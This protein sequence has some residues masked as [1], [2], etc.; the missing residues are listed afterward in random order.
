MVSVSGSM[1]TGNGAPNNGPCGTWWHGS[2]DYG[3][4][5]GIVGLLIGGNHIPIEC[6]Q[7]AF[8]VPYP[9]RVYAYVNDLQ[10]ENNSGS[11]S[12]SITVYPASVGDQDGDGLEDALEDALLDW[13][14]PQL[15]FDTE[16]DIRPCDAYYFLRVSSLRDDTN[17]GYPIVFEQAPF[18]PE[19]GLF[20]IPVLIA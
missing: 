15:K 4:T 13:Y 17:G 3:Y 18:Y 6:G 7:R 2:A 5:T 14:A 20:T 10:P 9:G 16:E 11:Y 12:V 8:V 19:P 1:N